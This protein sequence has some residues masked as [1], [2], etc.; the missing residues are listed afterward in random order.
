MLLDK[1]YT[2]PYR[3]VDALVDHF[4]KFQKEKRELPVVWHQSL[5]VFVQ[6]YKSEIRAEDKEAMKAL[7][8]AQ[9]HH[10]VSPEIH[11]ELDQSRSR[12]QRVEGVAALEAQGRVGVHVKEDVRDMAPVMV[13]EDDL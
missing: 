5:L 7:T 6:R 1:K 10:L 9:Y 12:G 13:M 8:R 4:C 11:R 3:V 2:L